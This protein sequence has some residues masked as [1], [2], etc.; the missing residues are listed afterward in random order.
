MLIANRD[1]EIAEYTCEDYEA[2]FLSNLSPSEI[3]EVWD[4]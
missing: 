1:E 3:E 4:K 2:D